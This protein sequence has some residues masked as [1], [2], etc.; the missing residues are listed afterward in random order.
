MSDPELTERERL[1]LL[2][3][4]VVKFFNDPR[5]SGNRLALAEALH[6]SA[7]PGGCLDCGEA[8]SDPAGPYCRMRG[9]HA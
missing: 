9:R 7:A 2:R 1:R 8:F 5:L 6:Q 3:D 4:A